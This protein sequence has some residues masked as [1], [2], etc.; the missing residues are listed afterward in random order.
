MPTGGPLDQAEAI[1]DFRLNEVRRELPQDR[2]LRLAGTLP[3]DRLIDLSATLV[4]EAGTGLVFL[5]P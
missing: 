3:I 1:L 4:P 2:V 5:N